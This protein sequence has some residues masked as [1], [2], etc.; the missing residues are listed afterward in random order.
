[1]LTTKFIYI[2]SSVSTGFGFRLANHTSINENSEMIV[3][4]IINFFGEMSNT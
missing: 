2:L 4:K 1:M 3:F